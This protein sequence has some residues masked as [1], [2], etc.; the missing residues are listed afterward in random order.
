MARKIGVDE[1]ERKRGAATELPFLRFYH[2]K[3]IRAKTL[4]VLEALEAAEDATSHRDELAEIVL[5]L[6]EA[7]LAYYF[8]IPVE[9]AKV[10]MMARQ[11]T[12]LGIAGIL[13]VMGPVARR[14]IGGMNATQLLIVSKHIRHLME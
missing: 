11:T 5:Q 9:A 6:T 12:K 10:G 13:R 7:G 8:E 3:A 14:V 4:S 1:G 2:S